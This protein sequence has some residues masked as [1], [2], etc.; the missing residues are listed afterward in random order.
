MNNLRIDTDALYSMC[1]SRGW[2]T[3]GSNRQY[4]KMFDLARS[5]C[6]L[7]ELALVI[8]LCSDDEKFTFED[9]YKDLQKMFYRR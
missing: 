3:C 9:I 7:K 5:G 2:F 1:V 4:Q 8:W 6:N